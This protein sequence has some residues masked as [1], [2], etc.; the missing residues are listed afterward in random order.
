MNDYVGVHSAAG[1]RP[2]DYREPPDRMR[3]SHRDLQHAVS[4]GAF[5]SDLYYPLDVFPLHLPPLRERGAD[6]QLLAETFIESCG[7][8]AGKV[9]R[10]MSDQ[11][12]ELLRSYPWP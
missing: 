1:D 4:E 5:R 12:V 7:L 9:F 8:R 3:A 2:F 6:V 10:G 11:T